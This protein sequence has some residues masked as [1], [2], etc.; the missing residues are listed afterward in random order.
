MVNYYSADFILPA[1]SEPLKNGTVAVGPDGAILGLYPEDSLSLQDVNVTKLEGIIVPGFI[2]SHCHLELSY[3]YNKIPQKEGLLSFIK[4]II[5]LRKSLKN[6]EEVMREAD[7]QMWENGIVAVADVSNN[8]DSKKIK[9]NSSIY[10]YTFIEL[11]SFEPDKAKDVF[12]EGS[13][14]LEQFSP[15]HA[16]IVPHAPYSASKELFR[17]IGKFCGETGSPVTIHNQESEDEN[18]LY[19]YKSGEFLNFYKELGINIDFFKPQAR[20]SI[21]SII[22]LIP[23]Q[24]KTML[25]HN[26]YTSLK[27]I[28]FILRSNRSVTWCF[29]PNANLYIEDRLPKVEMFQYHDFNITVGTDS[30]ASNTSLCMLSELKTLHLNFPGLLLTET[31]NWATI[32][33]AKFLGIDKEYG[34][35]EKGKRPGLNLITHTEGLKISAESKVQKLV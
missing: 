15:L 9:E 19:R 18:K 7:R 20:N 10:Y 34:S 1:T 17:F 12:R 21:Q 26:T 23:V 33:G 16:S 5:S 4:N 11:L 25:V 2:N 27:D 22:P 35:I 28:Y 31:I 30:L 32:N 13:E 8:I 6:T 29:C 24:Q 14:L 3:L